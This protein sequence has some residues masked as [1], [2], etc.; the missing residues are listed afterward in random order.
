MVK[1]GAAAEKKTGVHQHL[2]I[3]QNALPLGFAKKC[4]GT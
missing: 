4:T 1:R 2:V 3:F